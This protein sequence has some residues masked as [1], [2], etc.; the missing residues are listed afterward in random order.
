MPWHRE[1]RRPDPSDWA[2]AAAVTLLHVVGPR[3]GQDTS[4]DQAGWAGVV[5]L[6][7]AVVQGVPLAWRRQRPVAV[8]VVVLAGYA[9]TAAVVGLVPPV[10]A[11][12]ATWSVATGVRDRNRATYATSATAT[13]TVALVLVAEVSRAGAGASALLAGATV[14][15]SLFGLLVRAERGRI[16]AVQD[17]ATTAERLRIARDLHDLVGHGLSAVAV[18][19]STAR[20]ALDAGDESTA[21]SALSA[22][23]RSSR[24]AM[25]EMRHLLGVLQDA[26][27]PGSSDNLPAP[28]LVDVAQLVDNMRRGGVSV[29]L[30]DEVDPE[31][32][33]P[34]VQLVAYRVVQES[35]TNAVKHAPGALA[36]VRISPSGDGLTVA[37]ETS[38]G[39]ARQDDVA[40]GGTG[41]DGIRARVSAAGGRTR[42]GPTPHGWLVEATLPPTTEE[43]P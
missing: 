15:V 32:V 38:G 18:Q 39:L 4:A 27:M 13:V 6:L 41:L 2:V 25:R 16:A 3:T 26:P 35:L 14:V 10:A 7:A 22:V 24:T 29:T 9:V 33:E 28:G 30:I 8:A 19:S 37:V 36:E 34:A 20:M 42:I 43:A 40:V 17:A 1:L 11:W 31:T 21:R 5:A 12:V 23:E